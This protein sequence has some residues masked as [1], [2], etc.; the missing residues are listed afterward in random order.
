MSRPPLPRPFLF[1]GAGAAG[2]GWATGSG[3]LGGVC[4]S[5]PSVCVPGANRA[6]WAAGGTTGIPLVTVCPET[7]SAGLP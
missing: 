2:A 4:G 3:S 7:L 5:G 6:F 1:F